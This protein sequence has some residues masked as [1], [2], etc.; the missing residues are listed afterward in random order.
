MNVLEEHNHAGELQGNKRYKLPGFEDLCPYDH[1]LVLGQVVDRV[2]QINLAGSYCASRSEPTKQYRRKHRPKSKRH[3]R[4]AATKS[5]VLSKKRA[6]KGA[7]NKKS[8]KARASDN[9]EDEGGD[10]SEE[11]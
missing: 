1:R 2:G 8:K 3:P 11:Y 4:Q 9:E 6:R 10:I 7:T 5:K